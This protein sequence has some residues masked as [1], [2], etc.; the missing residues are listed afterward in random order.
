MCVCV[1]V[2]L[3]RLVASLGVST[4]M[5]VS[6]S[7]ELLLMGKAFF[8]VTDADQSTGRSFGCWAARSVSPFEPHNND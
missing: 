2:Y 5:H 8:P 6:L 4:V 1:C 3:S 7:D